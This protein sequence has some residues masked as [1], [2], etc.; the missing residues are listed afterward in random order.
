MSVAT[1]TPAVAKPDHVPDALV[2]D[3]DLH[4]DPGLARDPHRRIREIIDQ[5]PP[6]FWT[7]RSGG[8][9]VFRGHSAVHRASRDT[10]MF[11][12]QYLSLEQME[13][14]RA[15]LPP[16]T[17]RVPQAFPI[18][19]DPPMHGIYRGPLQAVFSPRSI[20]LLRDS[21]R[22]L[23]AELID[24]IADKG[25]CEFMKAVA[26][27]L[28]V[29]VFLRMLGMPEDRYP[30]YRVMVE[31]Y[32]KGTN[33][34]PRETAG[35]MIGVAAAMRDT[36][37]ARRDNLQDDIISLLWKSEIN[38]RAATIEDLEN[39][40]VLLFIAGLDTVMNG[41]GFAIRHLAGDPALQRQLR[42]NPKLIPEASEEMLR[43]YTFTVPPRFVGRDGEF[44]G[45]SFKKGERVLLFL[46]AADLDGSEFAD[47]D[48]YS[49]DRENNVHIAFGAGPHRCL[50]SHLARVE[51][52][53]L[54]EEFLAR[55]PEF[56]IDPDH[57]PVFH[58][59]NVIGVD[60]LH[61]V[62]DM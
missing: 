29:R 62:W 28:P 2:Y 36:L 11:S 54:Y 6:I 47:P 40:G 1:L 48:G 27:P 56:R 15:A 16:G 21:I 58:G 38:G 12:N 30:E 46:P 49:L 37:L 23:A 34:D 13:A 41:M 32:M 4:N 61:L 55:I 25:A 8:I 43:R 5:T 59:G 10:A 9:W 26:E 42:D 18:N 7:P 3:F 14:M 44:E 20:T 24:A 35:R 53:I 19:L 45:V 52:Q 31:E 60:S 50:G 51:I 17:P 39:Y 57:P 33:G 22:A